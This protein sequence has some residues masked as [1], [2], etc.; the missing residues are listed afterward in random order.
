MAGGL[1]V[2]QSDGQLVEMKEQEYD[3]EYLLQG[4]LGTLSGRIG[5][6]RPPGPPNRAAA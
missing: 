4:L 1:Y 3:S 5:P 6:T 2:L